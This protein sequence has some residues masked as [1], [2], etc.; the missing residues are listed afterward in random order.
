M[1]VR[2]LSALQRAARAFGGA[3]GRDTRLARTARPLYE[4]VLSR[5]SG[6]NGIPWTIN[7]ERY[8]IDPHYRQ[9]LSE[10]YEAGVAGY[11]RQHVH[12][13]D[14]C[15]D[16]GASVGAYVL[17]FARWSCPGGRVVAF[18]PNPQALDVLARHIRMN[19]LEE[20]VTVVPSAAG[21]ASGTAV[22]QAAAAD[23]MARLQ[24]ANPLLAGAAVAITV[25]VTSL[26]AY[27]LK[28]H[29]R[30][31]WIVVDVEGFEA[32]VLL[33]ARRII[34]SGS[35]RAIVAEF[36][37][38]VWTAPPFAPDGIAAVLESLRLSPV[39]LAGQPDIYL[40]HGPVLLLPRSI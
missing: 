11:L 2:G 38:S 31:Q 29:V 8:R 30:P 27:C 20:T 19:N 24:T 37:P 26:D 5:A 6:R 25:P 9:Q 28:Q 21:A 3:I 18:E 34:A 1:H 40:Q 32:D 4:A 7:G 14:V 16:V 13:G 23:G 10:H 33:G 39:P 35:V 15:V 17:Q 22:L 12:A 36:H